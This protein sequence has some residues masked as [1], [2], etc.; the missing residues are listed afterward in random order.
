MILVRAP[1]RIS[2]AGGGTDLP[3]YYEHYGSTF[4]GTSIDKYIYV[5]INKT[6]DGLT[7][8]KYSKYEKV[9]KLEDIENEYIRESLRYF[10]VLGVEVAS[11]SDVPGGTGLGSSSAFL[12]ALL[13]ALHV[14]KYNYP[15]TKE[16]LAKIACKIEIEVLK[17]NIGLQDAYISSTGGFNKFQV[18]KDGLVTILSM[19]DYI[20]D[21]RDKFA[22]YYTGISRDASFIMSNQVQNNLRQA[23]QLSLYSEAALKVGDI[24]SYGKLLDSHWQLKK[25]RS[26][27]STIPIIDRAYTSAMLSG[28]IYGGKLSGAGGG[29]FLLFLVKCKETLR[30][31]LSPF[32]FKELPFKFENYGVTVMSKS[33]EVDN[34]GF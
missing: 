19:W 12:L 2:L 32:N 22:L 13:Q 20:K 25:E 29:G 5:A 3:S 30:K 4:L 11:F 17:R 15:T 8:L 9:T 16:Y 23:H 18:S 28:G 27:L 21:W 14:Y 10:D 6:F 34:E 1:L 7:V 33:K 24:E 31:A 26:P